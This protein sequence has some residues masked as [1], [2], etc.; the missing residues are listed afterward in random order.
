MRDRRE[1]WSVRGDRE[2]AYLQILVVQE[3]AEHSALPPV[4]HCRE[5][6]GIFG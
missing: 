3:A 6:E 4:E 1:N 2:E 5:I